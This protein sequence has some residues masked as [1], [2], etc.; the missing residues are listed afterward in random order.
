MRKID[1]IILSVC[2]LLVA[3]SAITLLLWF[4]KAEGSPA[5]GNDPIDFSRDPIQDDSMRE[6]LPVLNF[7]KRMVVLSAKAK[8]TIDGQLVSKKRYLHG[9][10]NRLAPYDFALTWGDM[11]QYL[12]QMKFRQTS[13]FCLYNM[14]KNATVDPKYVQDHMSNNHLIPASKNIQKAMKK[15]RKGDLIRIEGHLVNVQASKN[16]RMISAWN[17]SE[18]RED[19]GN[20]ACEIIYVTRLRIGDTIYE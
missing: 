3:G 14:K 8:Y 2:A 18:S 10:M 13:R 17:S 4:G 12:D 7:G 20:G 11:P 6:A 19:T 1:I 9:F 5:L 15:A 16:G